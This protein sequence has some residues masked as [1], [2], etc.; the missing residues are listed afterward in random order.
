MFYKTDE[1]ND[2]KAI[3]EYM[4]TAEVDDIL[5]RTDYWGEDISYLAA[6]VKKYIEIAEKDG[7]KAAL[8][9]AMKTF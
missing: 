9:A 4:K 1:A 5:K 8:E 7:M 2:D 3:M 6:D